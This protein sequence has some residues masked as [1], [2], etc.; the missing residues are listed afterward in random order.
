M[1]ICDRVPNN[2]HQELLYV[3]GNNRPTLRD[4][5]NHVVMKCATYWK[6]LGKNL[7]ID[8]DLLN[9]IEKDNPDK[10]ED[11]CDRMLSEW[12]DL[13]PTASW[14]IL[15][16]AMNK[17]QGTLNS[18]SAENF[19]TGADKLPNT[20]QKLDSATE[21]LDTV[22]DKLP[23][24]VQKIDTAANK[25]PGVV[26]KLSSAA[27]QLHDIGTLSTAAGKY[28]CQIYLFDNNCI[29]NFYLFEVNMQDSEAWLT[30]LP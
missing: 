27:G 21:K 12:L 22:A 3:L 7:D 9:I 4:I 25:L 18:Y 8:E 16:D 2:Y 11:C 1:M 6:Q 13:N 20:V 24:S 19:E 26:E 17:V 14:G 5:N 29:C 15:F 23:D 28:I 30:I 10:C